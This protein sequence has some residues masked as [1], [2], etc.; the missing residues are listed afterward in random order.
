[1]TFQAWCLLFQLNTS[2]Y[3]FNANI[4]TLREFHNLR[5]YTMH[6]THMIFFAKKIYDI[7][8]HGFMQDNIN[9]DLGVRLIVSIVMI[10]YLLLDSTVSCPTEVVRRFS[11]HIWP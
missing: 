10:H 5:S 9:F 2:D 3:F 4:A 6:Y 11:S 8:S 1:M 7:Q